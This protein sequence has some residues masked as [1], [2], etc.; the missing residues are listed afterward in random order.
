MSFVQWLKDL[1][2]LTRSCKTAGLPKTTLDRLRLLDHLYHGL[3]MEKSLAVLQD[4]QTAHLTRHGNYGKE[5]LCLSRSCKTIPKGPAHVG[6]SLRAG[7]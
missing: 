4:C 1:S 2:I 3:G 6:L 7:P 5:V